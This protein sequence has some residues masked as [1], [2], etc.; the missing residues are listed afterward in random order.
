M[1]LAAVCD[2]L[3]HG[4]IITID[5]APAEPLPEHPRI[6]W[7]KGSSTDPSVVADV[8]QRLRG[9]ERV[10]V[11]LDADHSRAHVLDEL[12]VYGD[13]VSVGD[14]LI[15]ED[16]NV[17]GHPV[18]PEHGPGPAEAVREFLR[19]NSHYT[20]DQSRERLLITANPSGFLRRVS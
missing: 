10:M 15:V 4:Q 2:A 12:A 14:Y 16:T 6:T 1:F 8:R 19:D 13:I 18:L 9:T 20:V 5:T 3:D 17:N 7:L 11:I